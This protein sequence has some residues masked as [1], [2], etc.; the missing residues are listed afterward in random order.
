MLI[1]QS[2]N[3]N[4]IFNNKRS[5]N[6]YS[7]CIWYYSINNVAFNNNFSISGVHAI[8]VDTASCNNI[9]HN[10]D[11]GISLRHSSD[12]TISGN[13]ITDN[14]LRGIFIDSSYYNTISGNT[15]TDNDHGIWLQETSGNV[16]YHNNFMDNGVQGEDDNL[17]ENHWYHPE[18]LEG[19][20]WSDYLG[21]DLDGDGIGDTDLPWPAPG[22]KYS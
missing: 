8:Y 16:I 4:L 18:L 20:Y 19:N 5:N 2:S 17:A 3:S 14:F 22:I 11:D 10:N 12:N 7:L 13:T 6:Q 21:V 1:D 9:S 15:I